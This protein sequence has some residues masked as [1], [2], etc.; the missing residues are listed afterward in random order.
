M[1]KERGITLIALIIT[2][3]VLIILAGITIN[4]LFGQ[5]S[6]IENAK[7]GKFLNDF[8]SVE[9]AVQLHG[10]NAFIL[11]YTGNSSESILIGKLTD[12][13]KTRIETLKAE[14][15]RISKKTINEVNLYWIDKDKIKVNVQNQ[16]IIDVNSQQIYDY[17]GQTYFNEIHHTIEK[18][19]GQIEEVIIEDPTP[20]DISDNKIYTIEDLVRF[21][22]A[23]NTGTSYSGVTVTLMNSL[24]FKN[25]KSYNNS[26]TTEFGDLNGDEATEAIIGE[27]AKGKGFTPIANGPSFSGIFE[28]QNKTI[29][30]MY[31]NANGLAGLFGQ[32][33]NAQILNLTIKEANVTSNAP[34]GG[35]VG[36][37]NGTLTIQNC[38]NI[39]SIIKSTSYA[40]GIIGMNSATIEN[41]VGCSNTGR[42]E[43]ANYAGGIIG[44]NFT[45]INT[46][47]NCYNEGNIKG[48][49]SIG[50][51][52]GM[53]STSINT[54]QNCYNEGNIKGIGTSS[55]TGGIIGYQAEG[56]VL[57][58]KESYNIGK[59]EGNGNTGGII[60]TNGQSSTS[61]KS[62]EDCYNKGE[63]I[64]TDTVGGLF[65][66]RYWK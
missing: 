3:I 56:N 65:R 52:I 2:I 58:I 35:I 8:R 33:A 42:V 50:G 55:S 23:V 14:V 61:I 40:G 43:E 27:L 44:M 64:G 15:E 26:Q 5:N 46:I 31:I 62:V 59:V 48:T 28:G 30:N 37:S 13:E 1:K 11:N 25:E 34:T 22:N 9:E 17:E 47:Q 20:T 21:S 51:I 66:T 54:I 19:Q 41:L 29:S 38:K 6:V 60:G 32:T 12:E 7:R 39:D 45:S 53:N 10:A 63:I 18:E 4:L 57:L 36:N 16:Y 24:D 49:G